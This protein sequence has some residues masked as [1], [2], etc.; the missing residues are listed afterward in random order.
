MNT[1]KIICLHIQIYF[2]GLVLHTLFPTLIFAENTP[3]EVGVIL[4]LSGDLAVVGEKFRKGIE[5]SARNYEHKIK[6]IFQDG[7]NDA[8]TAVTAFR[9]ITATSHPKAIIGPW[10]LDQTLSIAKL[11]EQSGLI[12]LAV[13]A[14][15]DRYKAYSNIFC[16]Y[17]SYKEQ[18]KSTLDT[19]DRASRLHGKS[20]G[21]YIHES[22]TRESIQKIMH[23]FASRNKMQIVFDKSFAPNSTD[24]RSPL[25]K[26]RGVDVFFTA[27]YVPNQAFLILKQL[28]QLGIKPEM[29][30]W[31]SEED[32]ELIRKNSELLEGTYIIGSF[33]DLN[34]QFVDEFFRIEQVVPDLYHAIAADVAATL[35]KTL[36]SLPA[37]SDSTLREKLKGTVLS[38]PACK[39]FKFSSDR[40]VKLALVPKQISNGKVEVI[41]DLK[42]KPPGLYYRGRLEAP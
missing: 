34:S 1:V 25:L 29:R 19:F 35:F 40:T 12:V 13:T 36:Y 20:L 31:F 32:H 14:C 6:L 33:D 16:V 10:G 7:S 38:S 39:D 11:S 18:L 15:H 2:F 42:A 24:F 26:A 27:T 17:P 41:K 4:P 21:L 9:Q 30:W 5:F 37:V 28:H 22:E 23:S 3:Y 8:K